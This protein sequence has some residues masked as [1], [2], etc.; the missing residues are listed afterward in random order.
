MLGIVLYMYSMSRAKEAAPVTDRATFV[1]LF[2]KI[3]K[4]K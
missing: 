4:K 2:K 3:I 1:S